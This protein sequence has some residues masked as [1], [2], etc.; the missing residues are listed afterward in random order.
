MTSVAQ[1][2]SPPTATLA[3]TDP[4]LTALVCI[5]NLHHQPIVT[6]GLCA[7]L[8]LVDGRLTP[9]LFQRAAERANFTSHIALA[10]LDTIP[11]PLLPAI[12]LL[13]D[14][15]VC[16]L[17][18]VQHE[19]LKV[20]YP[21]LIQVPVD[22]SREELEASY[23]G[24]VI[25]CR[26]AYTHQAETESTLTNT[27]SGHWFW[28]VIDRYRYMYRDVLLTALLI[29]LFALAAPLFVMNVYDRV[30]PN[31]ATDTLWVLAVGMFI[32]ISA[33]LLLRLLRTR[34]V[35]LA[36]SRIDVSLSSSVMEHVLGMQLRARPAS[37]GAFTSGLQ[38]FEHI[39]QFL[40][41]A[42]VV[43]LVDLPFVLIF[44]AVIALINPLLLLPIVAGVVG[45]LA[46][47]R[48]AQRRMKALSDQSMHAHAMR[49]GLLVESVS[50]LETVK[51]E[52]A[53]SF[54]QSRWERAT[55]RVSQLGMR[56]KY[57]SSSVQSSTLWTAQTVGL[58]LLMLGVYQIIDGQLTQG[59]LIAAYMLSSRIMSPV[60]QVTSLL[61]QYQ[62]AHSALGALDEVMS[63]PQEKQTHAEWKAASQLEGAIDCQAVSFH[64]ADD[65][66]LVL[67]DISLSV[68]PGERVAILG[69][70]GSGKTS[71]EKLL[72]GLYLPTSG[73]VLL[74]KHDIG[75]W[76]KAALR[77]QIGY[78]GQDAAV[79]SGS[80]RDNLTLGL[81]HVDDAALWRALTA[82]GLAEFVQ[83]HPLGLALPV[84]EQGRYLSG[85]QKQ[86][87]CIARALLKSPSLYIFDEPTSA[88]DHTS[89]EE[90]K[91]HLL[92][93]LDGKTLI[94]I[95]HRTSLLE[96]V[97]RIIVM[98]AGRIVAD[99]PKAHV[100]DA[101][102]QGRIG[103][104]LA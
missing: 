34:F 88:M 33:D 68:A 100:M 16:I 101:L 38:S 12:L 77:Q 4:L 8:P 67:K 50:G 43:T 80:L 90:F 55:L 95:T 47:T 104:A 65:E 82:S 19:T 39:R 96:L 53:E 40:S 2:Y 41:S 75:Q 81:H 61:M 35:D 28:R 91:K 5:A 27:S 30:V 26:P 14:N 73:R 51:T 63:K 79:F 57:L 58:L 48:V 36:S 24:R 84:G 70:N 60:S 86:A 22:V 74:D 102:R 6:K 9:S 7:G 42:T 52:V 93:H 87:L 76:D 13:N 83:Q 97:D 32:A 31:Q 85:G 64:Y 62:Q 72:C 18:G 1:E 94:I 25:Y 21:E 92:T 3:T 69:R 20:I 71:L 45:I 98:D 29:N 66:R 99:G 59:G 37:V 15:R 17:V 49:N 44:I 103:R 11:A 56:M 78:V 89:E 10:T 23:T 54:Y 46:Y